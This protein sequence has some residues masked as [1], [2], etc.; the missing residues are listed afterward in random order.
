[1]MGMAQRYYRHDHSLT[2]PAPGGLIGMNG[3]D[4]FGDTIKKCLLADKIL[5]WGN[6]RC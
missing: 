1:M 3:L 6:R 4:Y 5:V 2:L